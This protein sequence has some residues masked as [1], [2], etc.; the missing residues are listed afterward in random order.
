MTARYLSLIFPYSLVVL[1]TYQSFF[2][3]NLATLAP[4]MACATVIL[5]VAAL[6]AFGKIPV[7]RF[8]VAAVTGSVAITG[9]YLLT[10][11]EWVSVIG[12]NIAYIRDARRLASG[13]GVLDSQY[14][15]GVKSMLIPAVV[16]FPDSVPALK[17][18][19]ALSG[20]LFP[21]CTFL[22]LREFID[23][24][25][26]LLI[27]LISGAFW[28]VV[29]YA[30]VVTADVPF[31]AFSLLALWVILKYI[32][33]PGISWK[34]L[35]AAACAVGWA[36]HVKSPSIYLVIAAAIYLVLRK[37]VMKPLLLAALASVWVLPWVL[38][39]KVNFPES[40]GY[41]GMTNQ[42]ARGV[43]IPE[44]Q[45]GSFWQNF[46]YYFFQKNPADYLQNLEYFLLP[47]EYINQLPISAKWRPI[48][49]FI[50]MLIAIGFVFGRNP[51]SRRPISLLR[52]LKVHD[53]YVMGYVVTLF[54]L[55]G[56][57]DRYL[58]PVL[59]FFVY[60]IFKGV[61]RVCG[62]FPESISPSKRSSRNLLLGRVLTVFQRR[63]LVRHCPVFLA[64]VF[65]LPSLFMDFA[66]VRDRRMT[67]GYHRYWKRYHEASVWMR[68]NTPSHSRVTTRKPHLVWFWSGRKSWGYPRIEDPA[69]ALRALRKFDY[70]LLDNIPI[71][72]EKLKYIV[73][74][75]K[76]Y[77]KSFAVVH[78]TESPET[79]VI[80][81]VRNVP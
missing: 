13:E 16:L 56:S 4:T 18:T 72:P 49:W 7:H 81:I 66:I 21:L 79:Y 10:C 77:P 29:E 20:F 75:G 28:I 35:I 59:P 54:T 76:A 61:E 68:D 19:V 26:A 17:A 80:K 53:W 6:S 46:F 27:A 36:Y 14:G 51:C 55:P 47:R 8:M 67:P 37:E 70:I 11:N 34:W 1:L 15:L 24:S 71:F 45:V 22:V 5:C 41:L 12:D 50:L 42:I 2:G 69:E 73:P 43:Y 64:C 58:L 32:K 44:G 25:R 31:P 39:L 74:V 62:R 60:Y 57:P 78:T 63:V 3:L 9:L 65:L 33:H 30:N 38:Y 23:D 40:Q 52:S 48:G